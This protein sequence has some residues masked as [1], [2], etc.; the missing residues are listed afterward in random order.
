[1]DGENVRKMTTDILKLRQRLLD[2]MEHYERTSVEWYIS[3]RVVMHFGDAF[4][5]MFEL[6]SMHNR[7]ER[8]EKLKGS[9][10]P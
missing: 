6:E 10:K 3:K 5:A 4:E 7:K 9:K 8:E 1:M 2:E